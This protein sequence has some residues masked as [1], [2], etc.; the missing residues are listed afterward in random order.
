MNSRRGW[1]R[2]AVIL[3]VAIPFML[4]LFWA[5]STSLRETGVPLPRHIDWFS[6]PLVWQNYRSV[7]EFVDAGRFALNS[8]IVAVVAVPA[9][10]VVASLAGFAMSQLPGHVRVR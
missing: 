4:P 9:T 2:V 10:I 7:F 6:S 3:A 1:W 8:L 5:V